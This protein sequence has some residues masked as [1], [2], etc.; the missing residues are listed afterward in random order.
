[1]ALINLLARMDNAYAKIIFVMGM[2]NLGIGVMMTLMR[3]KVFVVS[4]IHLI[5][6]LLHV[7]SAHKQ[8]SDSSPKDASFA[9]PALSQ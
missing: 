5:H 8:S 7:R 2:P 3:M 6:F 9:C 4:L 1:M